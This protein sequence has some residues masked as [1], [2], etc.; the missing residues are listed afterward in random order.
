MHDEINDLFHSNLLN[1]WNQLQKRVHYLEDMKTLQE[2][3]Q[4]MDMYVD[5]ATGLRKN[6]SDS[7]DV[8]VKTHPA[9][10]S[11]DSLDDAVL[12]RVIEQTYRPHAVVADV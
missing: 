3:Q 1:D 10:R 12:Q 8:D 9:D 2:M 5:D 7:M 6:S 11:L 4:E